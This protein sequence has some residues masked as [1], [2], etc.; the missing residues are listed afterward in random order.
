MPVAVLS[1]KGQLVIPA[2]MRRKAGLEAGD[3]VVIQFDQATQEIRLRKAASIA[4][5]IDQMS[6]HFTSLITPGTPPLED[7]GAFYESREPRL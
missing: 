6:A 3:G 5:E 1:T 2:E 7:V 4:N